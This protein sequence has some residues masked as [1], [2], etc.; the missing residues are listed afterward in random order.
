MIAQTLVYAFLALIMGLA[1]FIIGIPWPSFRLGRK[2]R[3][4]SGSHTGNAHG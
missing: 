4:K 1:V 3:N 2:R